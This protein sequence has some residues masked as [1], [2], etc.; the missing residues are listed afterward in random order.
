[1][2]LLDVYVF[3][4]SLI[5]WGWSGATRKWDLTAWENRSC[6][7]A[8]E[9][10]LTDNY[11]CLCSRAPWLC[12]NFSHKTYH[13][14]IENICI[15]LQIIVIRFVTYQIV[16]HPPMKLLPIQIY[17]LC[18]IHILLL[19][20]LRPIWLGLQQRG[21]IIGSWLHRRKWISSGCNTRAKC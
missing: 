20:R 19:N 7:S 6:S 12:P 2:D 3:M 17:A 8:H 1:M 21:I 15:C 16:P 4:W 14:L 11:T 9:A 5:L 18:P 13:C 10:F